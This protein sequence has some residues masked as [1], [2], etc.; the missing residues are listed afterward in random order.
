MRDHY[1]QISIFWGQ[2]DIKEVPTNGFGCS[3]IHSEL[4]YSTLT[5]VDCD[6]VCLRPSINLPPRLLKLAVVFS[7][8]H[9]V[10]SK[11]T[12]G[13]FGRWFIGWAKA[14]KLELLMLLRSS[15]RS[16]T[17]KFHMVGDRQEPWGVPLADG[18][19]YPF[20]TDPGLT[21]EVC[22]CCYY[23]AAKASPR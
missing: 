12:W 22:Q 9:E 3:S 15:Q 4:E 10:I 6:V 5:L 18:I 11:E 1:A 14:S 7:K 2:W 20:L 16:D 21:D 13:C 19:F 23:L 17:Y 8:N